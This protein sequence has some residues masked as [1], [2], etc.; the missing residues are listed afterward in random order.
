MVELS[1]STVCRE[2]RCRVCFDQSHDSHVSLVFARPVRILNANHRW[3]IWRDSRFVLCLL[4]LVSVVH[5]TILIIGRHL[6]LSSAYPSLPLFSTSTNQHR[7]LH[8]IRRLR[9]RVCR[10]PKALAVY[11][12]ST[13]HNLSSDGCLSREKRCST[14]CSCSC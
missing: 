4:S 8:D 14:I 3:L 1:T 11:L 7:R 2:R 13:S 12:Y 10:Y 5:W 9:R 6:S